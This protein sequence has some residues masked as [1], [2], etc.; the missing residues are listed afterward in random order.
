[1]QRLRQQ[2]LRALRHGAATFWELLPLQDGDL[3]SFTSTLV[4]LA[5]EGLLARQG[6]G[7]LALTAAGREA[8]A[9]LLPRHG[10][11]CPHC[12]GTGMVV[13]GLFARVLEQWQ[14]LAANRPAPILTFDQGYIT[15]R[16]TVAR[17]LFMYRRGDLEGRRLFFLGDDDLT[18]LAAALTGLPQEI[19]V[20]EIDERLVNFL[21]ATAEQHGWS[22]FRAAIYDVQEAL[23]PQ[24][25]QAFDV[26]VTD[27]VETRQ[28][29]LLFLSRCAE[30]L[31][32]PGSAVYFGLTR[33]ETG[34][35]KWREWL[36]SLLKMG[37]TPTDLLPAFHRYHLGSASFVVE[38]YPEARQFLPENPPAR[39]WYTSSLV[40][41]EATAPPQPLFRGP[42]H[43]GAALYRD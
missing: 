35:G 20:L 1:M 17:V 34:P 24:Y 21:N 11:E 7:S 25:R 5:D 2:I 41:L 12:E 3:A 43:L 42:V 14:R 18:S 33:L 26:A 22:H 8:A 38:E 16:D 4:A 36:E 40:R 29:F 28:G 39:H 15:P 13:E 9:R 32:G 37:L 30:T 31:A 19:Y 10:W 27:P 23:P 6:D